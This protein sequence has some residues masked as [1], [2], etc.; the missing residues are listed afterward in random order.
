MMEGAMNPIL[1]TTLTLA[2]RQA[3]DPLQRD[4]A[5]FSNSDFGLGFH[6]A[7]SGDV[8]GAAALLLLYPRQCGIPREELLAHLEPEAREV[9]FTRQVAREALAKKREACRGKLAWLEADGV[10]AF[11]GLGAPPATLRVLRVFGERGAGGYRVPVGRLHRL[12]PLLGSVERRDELAALA[13]ASAHLDDGFG[14]APTPVSR[15]PRDTVAHVSVAERGDGTAAVAWA[16]PFGPGGTA[17]REAVKRFGGR[18]NPE[19]LLWLLPVDHLGGL[20]RALADA[21]DVDAAA[22]EPYADQPEPDLTPRATVVARTD[23]HVTFTM[24]QRCD[25]VWHA[26]KAQGARWEPSIRGIVLPLDRLE[27]YMAACEVQAAEADLTA[28]LA[29]WRAQLAARAATLQARLQV[30]APEA[31][32]NGVTLFAHQREGIRFLLSA[33][34]DDPGI[35]GAILADDM[36]LGKTVQ[37]ILAAR[38]KAPTG[39]VLVVCPASLKGNWRNEILFWLGEGE[40]VQVLKGKRDVIDPEARWV[41]V[42]YDIVGAHQAAIAKGGFAVAALDEAHYCKNPDAQRTQALIGVAR[43]GRRAPGLLDAIPTVWALTGTPILNRPAE[44]WPLL[45]AIGHKHGASFWRF[46]IAY[47]NAH[48]TEW[49]WELGG[50]SNLDEL[51]A[52]MRTAYL[53]RVKDEVL[54]LPPKIQQSVAVALEPADRKA[55]EAAVKAMLTRGKDPEALDDE[56]HVL[57]ELNAL[58]LQTALAKIPAAIEL[59]EQ[60]VEAGR[61]VVIFTNYTEVLDRLQARFG[62]SA[63]RIDGSVAAE[64]R[65]AIVT[66]FQQD[67]GTRVF[68]GNIQAAGVGLTLTAAQDV[69]FVDMPWTPA[70]LDQAADRCY[71]IGQTGTVNVRYLEAEGTFDAALTAALSAKRDTIAWFEDAAAGEAEGDGPRRARGVLDAVLGALKRAERKAAR[72]AKKAAASA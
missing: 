31:A 69:L 55:Y 15:E 60:L 70:L 68:L 37:T 3:M 4:E 25:A 43:K 59:A 36:G 34:W 49:G 20:A 24:S 12:L 38:L 44:L 46:A 56:V 57:A 52:E 19:H 14:A 65:T 28:L 51:G 6:L 58:K 21:P 45:K 42:N 40:R 30:R 72:A 53:R 61:K 23:R 35:K 22:L 41:I 17:V 66:R 18:W 11:V 5:G 39:R 9:A 62:A 64:K 48:Q 50:A 54:D 63:V 67:P 32:P 71:R 8:Q 2:L 47:C 26:A 7:A 33:G 16:A 10:V 13:A 27:A 1:Q 29:V